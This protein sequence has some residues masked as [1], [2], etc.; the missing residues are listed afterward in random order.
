MDLGQLRVYQSKGTVQ[1]TTWN[2]LA[3]KHQYLEFRNFVGRSLK[4]LIYSSDRIVA[5]L[6]FCDRPGSVILREVPLNGEE[7]IMAACNSN[8]PGPALRNGPSRGLSQPSYWQELV[9]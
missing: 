8:T 5:A 6:V 7:V 1:E 3:R 4:Y 2:Y 9:M